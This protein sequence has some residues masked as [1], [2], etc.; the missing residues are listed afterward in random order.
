MFL[1]VLPDKFRARNTP[2]CT[3]VTAVIVNI[4]L[5]FLFFHFLVSANFFSFLSDVLLFLQ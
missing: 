5:P 4:M 1:A 2:S 3:I